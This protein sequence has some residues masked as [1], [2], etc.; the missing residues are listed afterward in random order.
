MAPGRMVRCRMARRVR[1][2]L[3]LSRFSRRRTAHLRGAFPGA[4][5]LRGKRIFH[6]PAP[7]L[8]VRLGIFRRRLR[9][10]TLA[11][12]CRCAASRHDDALPPCP[13]DALS[14]FDGERACRVLCRKKP[15]PLP[16]Q[17]RFPGCGTSGN[18]SRRRGA[19][20]PTAHK[21][22]VRRNR[23]GTADDAA[24]RV[25]HA[26]FNFVRSAGMLRNEIQLHRACREPGFA[27]S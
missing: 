12:S 7:R 20:L 8:A 18:F 16:R 24:F 23:R 27:I 9:H 13:H 11:R 26:Q 5:N 15:Q 14:C 19:A 10:R 21:F 22:P 6:D 25:V 2:A 4:E 1:C 3:E 17:L